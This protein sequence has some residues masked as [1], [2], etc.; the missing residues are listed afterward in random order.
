MTLEPHWIEYLDKLVAEGR[1]PSR[2][3]ALDRALTALLMREA[4][5][6]DLKR[7]IPL[8][9]ESGPAEDFSFEEVAREARAEWE[10][11]RAVVRTAAE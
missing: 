11:E 10:V 7:E 3:E 9:L 4:E 8:G 5:F 2:E 1:Y 6:R